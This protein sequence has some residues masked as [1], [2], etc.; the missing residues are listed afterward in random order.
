MIDAVSREVSDR[1]IDDTVLPFS[2]APLDL[3]GRLVRLGPAIDRILTRHAYPPVIARLVGEAAALTVLLGSA[4]K[5]E[6]RF[7]MQTR[8]DGVVDMIVVDFDAPDRLR[9]FARFDADKLAQAQAEGRIAPAELLGRG[10]LAFTIDQGAET[11]RY[12]G[13]V[14]LEGLGLEEAAHLYFLQSEQIP[15]FV[16]LAVGE[17][18]TPAG[19]AWRAGGMIV[20]FLPES[21]RAKRVRD[22]PPG[23]A[24]EGADLGAED[25]EDDAWTEG[26]AL[27]ATVEDHELVDPS[28]SGER[29][30]YRLFNERGVTVFE[31]QNVHDACRCSRDNIAIMLRRFTPQERK[32]MVGDNGVIGVTCEFCSTHRDFEPS[33]F[34]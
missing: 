23:D 4:L 9:A 21:Q 13:V 34:D 20:Q 12:Q 5:Y 30:L 24:P 28:L 33:E 27:A 7:Q 8:S 29:L 19:S 31:A 3:R 2:V 14:P 17:T 1:A 22:L 10:H 15:T 11:S 18:I 6:G 25:N 32:D 26:R 16:R